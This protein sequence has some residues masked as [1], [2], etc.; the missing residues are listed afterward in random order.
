MY[1][2]NET[3][4]P[5][6]KRVLLEWFDQLVDQRNTTVVPQLFIHSFELDWWAT[7]GAKAFD[8]PIL[9]LFTFGL[10]KV[11][12]EYKRPKCILILNY[13]MLLC[14]SVLKIILCCYSFF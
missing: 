1:E 3:V 2:I 11:S 10:G 7:I 14:Y 4:L 8:R 12:V 5:G 13:K 9:I 6:E